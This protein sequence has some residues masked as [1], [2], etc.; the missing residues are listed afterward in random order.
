MGWHEHKL[1]RSFPGSDAKRHP[2][3][4]HMYKQTHSLATLDLPGHSALFLAHPPPGWNRVPG[5]P[6]QKLGL[7]LQVLLLPF[8]PVA[9]ATQVPVDRRPPV[10][11]NSGSRPAN[12]PTKI[13][14]S[15]PE[16]KMAN[17]YF[18]KLWG[19]FPCRSD[20]PMRSRCRT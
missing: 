12:K 17:T 9:L 18:C 11:G 5:R 10:M 19:S 15:P 16:K 7:E 13:F 14:N 6:C 20:C 1:L 3:H 2:I 4:L 8:G